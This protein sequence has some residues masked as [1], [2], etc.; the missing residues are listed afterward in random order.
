MTTTDKRLTR[1]DVARICRE[2]RDKGERPD[3][4]GAN[5]CD[6]NLRG[7]NLCDADLR[8][9]NLRGADL[10]GA[11]LRGADLSGATLCNCN[12]DGALVSYRK[13]TVRV[14]FEEV[15]P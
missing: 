13:K 7:A 8:G 10:R 12:L 14:R 5:L 9:A 11:D 2:A 1:T 15:K 4:Y 3:L 6:A